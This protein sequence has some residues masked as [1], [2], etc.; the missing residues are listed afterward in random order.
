MDHP[1]VDKVIYVDAYSILISI[2][3]IMNIRL[4]HNWSLM[5]LQLSACIRLYPVHG[6]SKLVEFLQFWVCILAVFNMA[7]PGLIPDT[8]C[9]L[10]S[11]W[12]ISAKVKVHK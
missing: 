6:E 7:D 1:F 12:S 2:I 11:H 3:I 5:D 10:S 8:D 9:I 4:N